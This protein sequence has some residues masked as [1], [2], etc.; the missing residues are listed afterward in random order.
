MILEHVT[1]D[2]SMS[3]RLSCRSLHDTTSATYS[4]SLPK[5]ATNTYRSAPRLSFNVPHEG[6]HDLRIHG[7]HT[8]RPLE[9]NWLRIPEDHP[10]GIPASAPH[11]DEVRH[12][13]AVGWGV[14]YRLSA[15][16]RNHPFSPPEDSMLS[17]IRRRI[18]S[19]FSNP[20]PTIDE[21][22]LRKVS[23]FT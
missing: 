10:Y 1:V 17:R 2:T 5:V 13:M 11:G 18:K 20:R 15:L 22:L 21:D 16:I 9:Y 23:A 6:K 3:L 4:T 19:P 14:L 8:H 12:R 7:H